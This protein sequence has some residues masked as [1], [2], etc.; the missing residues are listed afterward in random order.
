MMMKIS[1]Y[2]LCAI[3]TLLTFL[4][5]SCLQRPSNELE[6]N[7]LPRI[8]PD[9]TDV[10]IPVDIAP[11]NFAVDSADLLYVKVQGSISGSLETSG[12]Y[13]DFD[14]DK[15]HDIIRQ[16]RG[17]DITVTVSTMRNGQWTRHLPFPIHVSQ[18]SLADYGIT[19]RKIAPGYETYSDI[20][21]YQRDIHSFD[22]DPIITSTLI[23]GQC[24]CCHTAN[25]ATP[26]QLTLH[27]RGKHP[28]TL[29]QIDGQRQWLT[30]KTDST[31]SNCMYPYWH[32]NGNFCAYSLSLVR[33]NFYTGHEKF[34]EVFDLASDACVL[35]VR[36]NQLILAP[37]LQSPDVE[38][39]PVFSADGNTIF[40]C[41]SKPHRLPAEAHLMRYD[42]CSVGFD[43]EQGQI[44]TRVDTLIKV[45]DKGHSITMP[46]PSYDGRFI[47]YC[48]TD[49]G[50]FPI[51]HPEA[52]LYILD[53]KT[54]E[55][56]ALTQ[57]NSSDTESFHNWNSNSRWI[58]FS[59]RRHDSMTSLAYFAHIDTLGNAS[60]PFLLPQ[61]NPREF[62]T[63]SLHSFNT[64][65]FTTDKVYIDPRATYD[66]V[67]S[68]ERTQ[69]TIK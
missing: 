56:H 44:G 17:A 63:N 10:T 16:N 29:I 49:Y 31:I 3:A 21:I 41:T 27:L 52:D 66:E 53:L 46:R 7:T 57:A 45:S 38:T 14:I 11:L 36:T 62:Y 69:V 23:P 15:W 68:D 32:P 48:L 33:Q 6:D 54:M 25:R 43:A 19:Y 34:I 60:K 50:Y 20:G 22:E 58:V 13:A 40:F 28:A 51:D 26:R 37:P 65:D 42:L 8:W 47:I 4:M 55:S 59:S 2:A 64:P 1:R 61:R 39:Y 30:T 12:K 9:Y 67:F 5:A 18:D 24:M 35:D